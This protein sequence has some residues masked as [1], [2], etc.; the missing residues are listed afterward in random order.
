MTA[1]PHGR[2][3]VFPPPLKGKA[4]LW[5]LFF[6]KRRSWMDG[7]YDRS[8]EMKMGEVRL[9]GLHLYMVNQPDLVRRVMVDDYADFPKHKMMGDIL[10]PLLGESIF[11]TNGRQWQ[12]QRQMLNPAFEM[13]RVQYVFSLM[14]DAA[15]A[16]ENRLRA[17]EHLP[18]IDIDHEMTYVTADIIF[19]TILSINLEEE[20][21]R[22]IFDAFVLFQKLSPRAALGRVFNLPSWWPFGRAAE[23]KRLAAGRE[24]HEAIARVIRPRYDAGPDAGAERDILASLLKAVDPDTGER[25]SFN[26]I[27]D[28]VAMLFLAGHE[29][30]ASALTWSVYLLSLHPEVQEEAHREVVSVLA[31]EPLGVSAIRHMDLVRDIFREA[32]RL[33]PPVGFFARECAKKTKMR[34]KTMPK[35][36]LV[37]VAPWLIHRHR[38]Y[39]E[40]PNDFDPYRFSRDKGKMPMRDI[41]LPFGMGPRVCI[42]TAFAMQEAGLILAVLLKHYR[43]SLKPGFVPEPVGRITVRSDNGMRVRLERRTET[44]AEAA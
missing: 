15:A 32:L 37:V 35:G 22:R 13:A 26:E 4:A 44:K 21:A 33:Y 5:R 8:Y 18:D 23:K 20:E 6:K 41:W 43:I 39:W 36:S 1:S 14:Q 9:P 27:V 16:M 30:S 10:E 2:C 29:T 24:I 17:Q 11:T 25:F 19:R 40:K 31:Q 7:L 28:Q 3:P 12:K 34:K 38:D 42:G